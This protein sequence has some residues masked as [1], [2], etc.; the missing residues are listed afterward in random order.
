MKYLFVLVHPTRGTFVCQ[1]NGDI[2]AYAVLAARQTAA[3]THLGTRYQEWRPL[4]TVEG[5]AAEVHS[6]N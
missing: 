1:G 2:P 3:R 4:V 6:F 5:D